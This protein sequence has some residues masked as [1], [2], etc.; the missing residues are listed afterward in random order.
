M[1]SATMDRL[2]R[3]YRRLQVRRGLSTTKPGA[4]LKEMIPCQ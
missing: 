2:I 3:P 1:S 4:L